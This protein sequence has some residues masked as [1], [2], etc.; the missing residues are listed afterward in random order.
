MVSIKFLRS[1]LNLNRSDFCRY[2]HIPYRTVFSWET[3]EREPPEYLAT[4]LEFYIKS[5]LDFRGSFDSGHRY[6]TED[7]SSWSYQSSTQ[8]TI[9]RLAELTNMNI[10]EF[11]RYFRIPRATVQEWV[12]GN[13]EAPEYLLF[14]LDYY[15]NAKLALNK[16]LESMGHNFK[17]FESKSSKEKEYNPR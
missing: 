2:F 17:P 12:Q 1:L 9:K 3:G 13:T 7:S 5:E 16:A 6:L 15:V 4:L 11:S 8:D 14:L 10:S